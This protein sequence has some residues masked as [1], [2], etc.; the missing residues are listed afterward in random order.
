MSGIGQLPKIYEKRFKSRYLKDRIIDD[1]MWGYIPCVDYPIDS[2]SG[3]GRI[4]VN[5]PLFEFI[6][7]HFPNGPF[8]FEPNMMDGRFV[9]LPESV[10]HQGIGICASLAFP[11][12][13]EVGQFWYPCEFTEKAI[14]FGPLRCMSLCMW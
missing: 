11:G 1:G 7:K 4:E 5:S 10:Y 13:L 6:D 2:R 14:S 12:A 8:A 3:R 9:F